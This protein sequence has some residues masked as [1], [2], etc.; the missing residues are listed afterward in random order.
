MSSQR[1]DAPETSSYPI[2]LKFKSLIEDFKILSESQIYYLMIGR[3]KAFRP[4][5]RQ[6]FEDYCLRHPLWGS[7]DDESEDYTVFENRAKAIN[8]HW[9]DFLRLY[10][11]LGDYRSRHI[12]F[13]FINNW[14]YFD[15]NSLNYA[16]EQ[17]FHEYF[18]MD[19]LRCDNNEVFVD[20]GTSTGNDV[21]QYLKTYGT[22]TFKQMYCYEI[23]AEHIADLGKKVKRFK[24]MAILHKA[25]SDQPA[26][27]SDD[28]PIETVTIDEDVKEPVTFIKIH[29]GGTEQKVILGCT[30]HIK[31][32]KPKLA[33][34]VYHSSEDIWKIPRTIDEICPG[35]KFYL[36]YQ[37]KSFYPTDLTLLAVH[38]D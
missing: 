27:P 32:D 25:V 34:S 22:S 14:Y 12:L 28:L 37:G 36:R 24:N 26:P 6:Q 9:V 20:I 29:T 5:T 19:I 23:S 15:L 7:L 16:R 13:A 10:H 30:E 35:Y 18:D 31:N 1:T 21:M 33:V 8:L 17:L 38:Q 2:D 4:E 11:R 3:Y